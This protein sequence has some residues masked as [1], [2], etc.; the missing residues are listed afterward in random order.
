MSHWGSLIRI[1]LGY[2]VQIILIPKYEPPLLSMATAMTVVHVIHQVLS[3]PTY[4]LLTLLLQK[5]ILQRV[6]RAMFLKCKQD[7]IK[8]FLIKYKLLTIQVLVSS[9]SCL[10]LHPPSLYSPEF[11]LLETRDIL[12]LMH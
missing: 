6:T 11:N 8:N 9:E 1:Y 4:S 3:R 10:T 5:S 7:H 2:Q 12:S